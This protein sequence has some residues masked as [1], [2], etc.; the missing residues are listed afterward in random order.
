MVTA[1]L[2]I[3][4]LAILTTDQKACMMAIFNIRGLLGRVLR[5]KAVVGPL[6]HPPWKQTA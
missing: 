5:G 3:A 2:C 6:L 1:R 4:A